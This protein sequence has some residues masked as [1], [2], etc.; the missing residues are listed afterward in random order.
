MARQ[1]RSNA[2]PR[3]HLRGDLALTNP[4]CRRTA[5]AK[6]KVFMLQSSQQLTPTD[7]LTPTDDTWTTVGK[8]GKAV[9]HVHLH[10]PHDE[11]RIVYA[12]A[13]PA[14]RRLLAGDGA[15]Q[16]NAWGALRAYG[17]TVYYTWIGE[18]CAASWT[19][20]GPSVPVI[21]VSV[22]GV[23]IRPSSQATVD[24]P[25]HLRCSGPDVLRPPPANLLRHCH[26]HV[27]DGH[28]GRQ[29]SRPQENMRS[30]PLAG[31]AKWWAWLAMRMLGCLPH[32]TA[33]CAAMSAIRRESRGGFRGPLE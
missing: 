10:K 5:F 1:Q 15:A 24:L 22:H 27:R 18:E 32:A 26:F 11:A 4:C 14:A 7:E 21:W 31:P 29:P 16:Q 12:D 23:L 9:R 2:A 25:L 17:S 19:R 33:P 6:L 13:N 3:L 30:N 20:P 28:P 8:R